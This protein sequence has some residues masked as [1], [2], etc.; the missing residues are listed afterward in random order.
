MIITVLLILLIN[1]NYKHFPH[2]LC[3][4]L[5]P[6]FIYICTIAIET[7]MIVDK[8]VTRESVTG[9]EESGVGGFVVGAIVGAQDALV[10]NV[11]EVG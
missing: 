1:S 11:Q 2:S 6:C 10:S 4:K 7:I 9:E 8:T 5:F 3:S